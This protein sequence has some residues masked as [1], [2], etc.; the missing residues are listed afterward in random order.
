MTTFNGIAISESRLLNHNI[1]VTAILILCLA[2][3]IFLLCH[4]IKRYKKFNEKKGKIRN[5]F[6]ANFIVI[7]ILFCLI[8]VFGVFSVL[9]SWTDYI[10]KD[11]VIYIGDFSVNDSNTKYGSHILLNDGTTLTGAA[12]FDAEDTNGH[13]VYSKRSKITLG[14]QK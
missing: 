3:L 12:D 7:G 10:K 2:L 11:Y 6:V 14:G 1:I 13:V 4:T 5:T 8:I 9:P